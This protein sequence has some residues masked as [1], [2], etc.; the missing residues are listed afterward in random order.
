MAWLTQSGWHDACLKICCDNN[1]VIS[2]FWKGCSHNPAH[3]ETLGRTTTLLAA[4][5]LSIIPTYIPSVFNK[6]DPLSCCVIGASNLCIDP[7]V[8]VPEKLCPFII[9]I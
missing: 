9:E 8:I 7:C 3:N 4:T 2:S 6:A 1:S 5:N